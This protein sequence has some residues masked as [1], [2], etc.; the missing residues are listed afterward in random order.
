[1]REVVLDCVLVRHVTLILVIFYQRCDVCNVQESLFCYVLRRIFT[2]RENLFD[3]ELIVPNLV[4]LINDVIT[5]F[6]EP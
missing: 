5:L 6:V 1:M 4:I 2:R 3:L